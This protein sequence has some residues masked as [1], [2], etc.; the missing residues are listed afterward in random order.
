M[1]SCSRNKNS[2]HHSN[3]SFSSVPPECFYQSLFKINVPLMKCLQVERESF[4]PS[5]WTFRNKMT[6][7]SSHSDFSPRVS[8]GKACSIRKETLNINFCASGVTKLKCDLFRG[9]QL[10][11]DDSR[12]GLRDWQSL[13]EANSSWEKAAPWDVNPS[14]QG[15]LPPAQLHGRRPCSCYSMLLFFS[16]DWKSTWKGVWKENNH[17]R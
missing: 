8:P 16:V 7:F 12:R 5:E 1:P 10:S 17:G 9:F 13:K 11:E 6:C 15:T 2:I 4:L 3:V 14:S